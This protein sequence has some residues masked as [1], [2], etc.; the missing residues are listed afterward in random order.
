[1][2]CTPDTDVTKNKMAVHEQRVT[3]IIII[4]ICKF[5]TPVLIGCLSLEFDR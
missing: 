1:M 2:I 5:F 4:I 3:N